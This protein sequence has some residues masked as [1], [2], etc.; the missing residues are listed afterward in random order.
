MCQMTTSL[1]WVSRMLCFEMGIKVYLRRVCELKTCCPLLPSSTKLD[2]GLW[3]HGVVRRLMPVFDT[4][5]KI[6]GRDFD[7]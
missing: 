7:H 6:R 2:F 5:V 4:W 1:N 3:S